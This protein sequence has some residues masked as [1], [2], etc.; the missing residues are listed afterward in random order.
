MQVTDQLIDDAGESWAP[1]VRK[2]VA[3]HESDGELGTIY[4]DL[5]PRSAL[6]LHICLTLC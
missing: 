5:F 3:V 6:M 2:M 4:L 1:G